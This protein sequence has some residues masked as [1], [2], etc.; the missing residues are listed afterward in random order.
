MR[1]AAATTSGT[2]TELKVDHR[3]NSHENIVFTRPSLA[4]I[5]HDEHI[6]VNKKVETKQRNLAEY[7]DLHLKINTI[8][9]AV[10]AAA[11]ILGIAQH[12][13]AII[14]I[15]SIAMLVFIDM[16]ATVLVDRKFSL[17]NGRSR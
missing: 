17:K 9:L 15:G 5:D 4:W 11:V 13:L 12:S 6:V 14:S 10:T 1:L 2:L 16:L 3:S 8:G 7:I